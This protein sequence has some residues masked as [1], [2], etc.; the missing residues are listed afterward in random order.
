MPSKRAAIAA[1]HRTTIANVSDNETK[2]I[3]R[4]EFLNYL[5]AG[6]IATGLAGACGAAAWFATP[7][8]GFG[9]TVFRLD[10]GIVPPPNSE[11]VGFPQAKCWLR[12]TDQ[13]LLALFME[14]PS[15]KTLYKWVEVNNRFECPRFGSKFTPD[16]TKIP[17]QGPAPRNLDRFVIQVNTPHGIRITPPDGSPVSI[18]SATEILINTHFKRLGK[19][20]F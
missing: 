14:C 9:K 2:G 11:P 19:T 1:V 10:F 4:R 17:G 13:G 18:E 3:S 5:W 20:N 8:I 16:G 12:N 7:P 6:S 15:D